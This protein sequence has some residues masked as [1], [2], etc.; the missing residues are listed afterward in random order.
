MKISLAQHN[1]GLAAEWYPTKNGDLTPE[2]VTKGSA[3]KVW[4]LCPACGHEWQATIKDRYGKQSG[5]TICA[6]RKPKTLET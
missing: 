4:W 6:G 2:Q 5:C 1:P 3:K